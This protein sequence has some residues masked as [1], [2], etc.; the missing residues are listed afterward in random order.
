M[1]PEDERV[2]GR[3]LIRWLLPGTEDINGCNLYASFDG[4]SDPDMGLDGTI[5]LN[6]SEVV[7]LRK[8]LLD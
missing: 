5:A 7:A 8:L 2:L 1:T 4:G 6:Y 3:L